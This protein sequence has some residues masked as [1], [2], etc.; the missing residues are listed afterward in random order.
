MASSGL[1]IAGA[2]IA[3]HGIPSRVGPDEMRQ[4]FAAYVKLY[5]GRDYGPGLS[6]FNAMMVLNDL[7][8]LRARMDVLSRNTSQ[9]AR[10]LAQQAQVEAVFYPGLEGQPGHEIAARQMWLADGDI[11]TSLPAN[12]YGHM[13]GFTVRGG[14]Q[15]ARRVFDAFQLIWR[16][17]DLGRIQSIATI[18][19]VST[20]Q[21]QG[22]AGRLLAEVPDNLIRL[23]VGGE[24]VSD[25]IADLE[26]ALSK[27]SEQ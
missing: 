21:Q 17:T 10:F 16:A 18:P 27:G 6:P 14:L 25:I 4:N 19:S 11:D 3:R 20:H 23:S 8:T 26:Q 12:R 22:E 24:A 2:I 15:A 1:A 13:L 5:P 7:R 9:V